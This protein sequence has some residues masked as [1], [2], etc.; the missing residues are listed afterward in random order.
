MADVPAPSPDK[1]VLGRFT[2]LVKSRGFEGAAQAGW[3]DIKN[4]VGKDVIM[5]QRG[6]GFARVG[7]IGVGAAMAGDALFAAKPPTAKIAGSSRALVNSFWAPVLRLAALL[8]ARG[9][10]SA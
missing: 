8:W 7:G 1:P 6:V 10:H 2:G 9:G 5:G 3:S 4:I